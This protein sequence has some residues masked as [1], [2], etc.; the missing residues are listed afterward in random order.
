MKI[1]LP[2]SFI[3]ANRSKNSSAYVKDDILYVKGYVNFEELMYTIA[4][5]VKGYGTCH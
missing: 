3:Y 5:M 4:Y 1:R 2:K